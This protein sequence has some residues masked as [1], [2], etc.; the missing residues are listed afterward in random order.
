L[1]SLNSGLDQA[2]QR[3]AQIGQGFAA[4]GDLSAEGLLA[5]GAITQ[6]QFSSAVN[7]QNATFQTP[8]DADL[9]AQAVLAG[10][11]VRSR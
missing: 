10:T 6:G 8:S 11:G 7:I 3:Q 9:V 1:S 5:R 2:E 4:L